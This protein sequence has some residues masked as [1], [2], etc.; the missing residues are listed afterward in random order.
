[1][2]AGE[3]KRT[4]AVVCGARQ[5]PVLLKIRA[6]LRSNAVNG[7]HLRFQADLCLATKFVESA[8]THVYKHM[9]S[10][11]Q[12]TVFLVANK[13]KIHA[14]LAGFHSLLMLNGM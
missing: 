3:R 8:L 11:K 4:S 10:R 5:Q 12:I 1:M 14:T 13:R 7:V 9:Q 6:A 2:R